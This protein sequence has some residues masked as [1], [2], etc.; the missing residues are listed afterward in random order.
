M[1]QMTKILAN[2]HF[3]RSDSN[4]TPRNVKLQMA[5]LYERVEWYCMKIKLY[6][7]PTWRSYVAKKTQKLLDRSLP[8]EEFGTVKLRQYGSLTLRLSPTTKWQR[9]VV[10]RRHSCGF[11]FKSWGKDGCAFGQEWGMQNNRNWRAMDKIRKLYLL[12]T[13]CFF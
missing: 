13:I 4:A 8:T 12:P 10:Q 5:L 3:R 6:W 7:K 1:N 11:V 9:E 2:V